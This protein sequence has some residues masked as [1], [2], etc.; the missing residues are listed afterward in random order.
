M[1]NKV[2]SWSTR[3]GVLKEPKYLARARGLILFPVLFLKHHH[4]PIIPLTTMNKLIG[5]KQYWV[6]IAL[7]S[8]LEGCVTCHLK[9]SKPFIVLTE[10]CD[11]KC[12]ELMHSNAQ[13]LSLG[14][15][16]HSPPCAPTPEVDIRKCDG[17]LPTGQWEA[18]FWGDWS[19]V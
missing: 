7:E 1:F 11:G 18:A 15:V 4:C 17:V 3:G 5:M 9:E 16:P 13:S 8:K 12:H 19:S 6:M 10:V 14:I 2:W